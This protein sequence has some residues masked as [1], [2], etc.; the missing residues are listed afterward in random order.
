[1][2]ARFIVIFIADL[3]GG[4]P[5]HGSIALSKRGYYSKKKKNKYLGTSLETSRLV[6]RPTGKL[7]F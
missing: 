2:V 3:D 4:L 1:M 7:R 5:P 6:P